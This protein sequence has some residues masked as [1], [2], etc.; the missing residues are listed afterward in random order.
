MNNEDILSKNAKEYEFLNLSYNR[1]IDTILN[2]HL[3][4]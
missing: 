4:K 3:L 1:F 2:F